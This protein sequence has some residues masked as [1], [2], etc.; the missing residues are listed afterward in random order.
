MIGKGLAY[1][2]DS[3]NEKDPKMELTSHIPIC[4]T[5]TIFSLHFG[6]FYLI[7][8]SFQVELLIPQLQFLDD[9]GAQSELWELSR[10]FIDTLIEET[11]CQ[12]RNR[13][14]CLIWNSFNLHH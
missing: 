3:K 1:G 2:L 13:T 12:V 11:G 5:L 6:S 9:E 4:F 7:L 14:F 8:L 10:V